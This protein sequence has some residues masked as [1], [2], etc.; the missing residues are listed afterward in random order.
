MDTHTYIPTQYRLY[1]LCTGIPVT[2]INHSSRNNNT[3]GSY[4]CSEL[5][6]TNFSLLQMEDL[7]FNPDM[8]RLGIHLIS[9][10]CSEGFT[11]LW[12]ACRG[13]QST[14]HVTP[15]RL[16]RETVYNAEGQ[17]GSPVDTSYRMKSW[18]AKHHSTEKPNKDNRVLS[19]FPFHAHS[20]CANRGVK[21]YGQPTEHLCMQTGKSYAKTASELESL[22]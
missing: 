6:A 22:G 8:Y 14:G 12:L 1:T 17:V 2:D 15:S 18:G 13:Q 5:P 20:Q 11:R 19:W 16:T 21:T 3:G 4:Y 9:G 10:L 7:R